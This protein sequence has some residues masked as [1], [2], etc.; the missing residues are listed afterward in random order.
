MNPQSLLLTGPIGSKK[1][2]LA[3][4]E[5]AGWLAIDFPLLEIHEL[6]G[7]LV[8]RIDGLPDWIAVTSSSALGALERAIGAVPELRS[9]PAAVVGAFT[10]DRVAALGLSV[11]LGPEGGARAL[12][13]ALIG[14]GAPA[15]LV[16]WPRGSHSDSLATI[17][18]ESG[19][20]V[21]DPVVYE[22]VLRDS[23]ELPPTRAVFFASPSAVEAYV[24][25]G[26]RQAPPPVAI[27]IGPTTG[28][29]LEA[30]DPGTFSDR[31]SLAE[32][33]PQALRDLLQT[34]AQPG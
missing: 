22:T 13:D 21:I 31:I 29:A 30:A 24:A 11:E 1:R 12:A 2:W 23:G 33:A 19:W 20:S 6:D 16:L 18:R 27:A 17:L 5:D 14:A 25:R 8:E 26:T 15:S 34:L 28:S 10:A 32:P 4:A 7:D 3:A 9:V